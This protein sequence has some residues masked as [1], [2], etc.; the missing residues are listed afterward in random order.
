[1]ESFASEN[2]ARLQVME[3]AD[4]TIDARLQKLDLRMHTLRQAAIT[5]ELLDVITGAEA[6]A[7]NDSERRRPL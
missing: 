4:R 2:G 3:A 5:E 1:M 6:I 7:A